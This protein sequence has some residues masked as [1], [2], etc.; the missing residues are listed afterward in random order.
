MGKV[1]ANNGDCEEEEPNGEWEE[2]ATWHFQKNH[3]DEEDW[4][5]GHDDGALCV[6]EWKKK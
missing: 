3:A 1:E 6:V 4:Q 2:G 5:E